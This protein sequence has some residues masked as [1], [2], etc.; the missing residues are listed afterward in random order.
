MRNQN[1]GDDTGAGLNQKRKEERPKED[2]RLGQPKCFFSYLCMDG[3]AMSNSMVVAA[4]GFLRLS[5][6]TANAEEEEIG[7]REDVGRVSGPFSRSPPFL[8]LSC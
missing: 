4:R 5:W 6:P 1:D 2:N 7:G 3:H 8:L